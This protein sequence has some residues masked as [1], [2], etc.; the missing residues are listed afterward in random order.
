MHLTT[1]LSIAA[2]FCFSSVSAGP[3]PC[4]TP[5]A[6][7][8]AAKN[9]PDNIKFIQFPESYNS[10]VS[11]PQVARVR[12]LFWVNST[13]TLRVFT[14]DSPI[15][16]YFAF[17]Q[18]HELTASSW[19]RRCEGK[20]GDSGGHH[21]MSVVPTRAENIASASCWCC[22]KNPAVRARQYS[23]TKLTALSTDWSML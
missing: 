9:T 20:C 14:T 11:M 2:A 15:R 18:L 23:R 5:G 16:T 10:E 3:S 17:T 12:G 19:R 7:K 13:S 8:T 21:F 1:L 22:I 6:C 4:L